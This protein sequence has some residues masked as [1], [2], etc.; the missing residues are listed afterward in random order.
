MR[1]NVSQLLKE[2]VGSIRTYTIND[3]TGITDNWIQGEV[4]LTRTDRGI[5]VKGTLQTK[6]E[7]ACSRCL[8]VFS[9]PLSLNFEDEYFPTTD[10]YS[11]APL[12]LHEES[13]YFTID[14]NH[15]I[16]LTEAIRQ[17]SLLAAPMKPLCSAVCAGLCPTCGH[18][19]NKGPCNCPPKEADPRWS[20]LSI[21]TTTN[22]DVSTN[23][24]PGRG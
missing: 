7:L 15:I 17:Y 12:N 23:R 1:I 20:K 14:E 6:I 19:L 22:N 16:D 3:T 13:D 9:Y 10:I 8:G 11:G 21:L 24:K 2:A 18:N 4:S 5:L